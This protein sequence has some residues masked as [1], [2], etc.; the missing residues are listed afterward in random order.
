MDVCALCL[1]T[2]AQICGRDKRWQKSVLLFCGE[3][4]FAWRQESAG[5]SCSPAALGRHSWGFVGLVLGAPGI[6]GQGVPGT[7]R[8]SWAQQRPDLFW[9]QLA[10][11]ICF[12]WQH[13]FA[14]WS[15]RYGALLVRVCS[16]WLL[17]GLVKPHVLEGLGAL[18]DLWWFQEFPLK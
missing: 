7:Y 15:Q 12:V 17:A 5:C 6:P 11:L 1:T 18:R 14:A 8:K 13:L 16:A 2:K 3:V 9:Q 10:Q 4:C